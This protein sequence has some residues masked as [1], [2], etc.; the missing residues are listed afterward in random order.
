MKHKLPIFV[1]EVGIDICLRLAQSK[2]VQLERFEIFD[3]IVICYNDKYSL[4][5]SD[6]ILVTEE[7]IFTSLKKEQKW[8]A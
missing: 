5:A 8:N 1:T 7:S 6:S 4:N 2:N 3:E